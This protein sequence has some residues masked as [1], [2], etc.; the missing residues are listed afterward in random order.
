MSLRDKLL[1]QT[2]SLQSEMV[3]VPEWDAV[4]GVRSMTAGAQARLAGADSSQA[5]F[6][7]I[8]ECCFDPENGEQLF[9]QGDLA[10]IEN[11]DPKAIARLGEACM[12][13]SGADEDAVNQGKGDS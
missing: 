1:S 7:A 3:E 2:P 5:L 13:V 12:K 9:Q 6:R 10:W 4:I 8:I 11:Q